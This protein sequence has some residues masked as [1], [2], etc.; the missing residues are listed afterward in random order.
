[1]GIVAGPDEAL[2]FTENSANKIGRI[3]TAGVVTEFAIPTASS[4]PSGIA[5]GPDGALWFTENAAAKIGRISTTGAFSEYATPTAASGPQAITAGADG[6]LWFT[7]FTANQLGRITTD[8]VITEYPIPTAA[9]GAQ[10]ITLGPD[11]AI[12]FGENAGNQIARFDFVPQ[13]TITC[14]VSTAAP[15]VG[16]FYSAACTSTG[17]IEPYTYKIAAGSLP[18]GVVLN[19]STGAIS[20]T[21]TAA[22]TFS[23]TVQVSDTTS[24][25]Q[26]VQQQIS[27]FTVAPLPLMM[28]C[29]IPGSGQVGAPY[30]GGGC[31]AVQGTPPYSYSIVAGSLPGGL[32]L[33][34]RAGAISGIPVAPGTFAFTLQVVDSSSPVLSV[35][36]AFTVT[37]KF[38][39]VTKT[40]TLLFTLNGF[41]STQPPASNVTN[42][43]LQL[44]QTA[45]VAVSGTLALSFAPYA[46]DSGLPASGTYM[47]PALQFVDNS[48]NKLGTTYNISIPATATSV[49]IPNIDPGTVAGGI[50][51]TLAMDSLAEATATFTV[52]PAVPQIEEGSVQITNMTANSFEVELVANSTTRDLQYVTFAFTPAAGSQIIGDSSFT[53]DVSSLLSSWFSSQ[54]GLEYGSA[55]SLTVPFILSGSVNAIQSVSVTLINTVGASA[56]VSGSK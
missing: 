9:S 4:E 44:N 56:T 39:A 49:A 55:F 20:G 26:V 37:I 54:E 34:P 38:G 22:G 42:L 30:S 48:G 29:S 2:W 47:D 32:T 10:T 25:S 45:G 11:G 7:E 33:D 15:Q 21:T 53:F 14:S 51:A 43:S 35:A 1:L 16:S 23:Y 12:W 50:T 52:P 17:G 28:T 18:A 46:G 6:A 24:P 3:T 31:S 8:G 36:Q 13:L 27:A 40:G 19:S 5:V 41:P